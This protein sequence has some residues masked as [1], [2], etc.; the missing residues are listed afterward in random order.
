[1]FVLMRKFMTIYC[2]GC[3]KCAGL[4]VIIHFTLLRNEEKC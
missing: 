3:S 1:M 4:D 2:V